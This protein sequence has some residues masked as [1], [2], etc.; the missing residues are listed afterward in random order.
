MSLEID[1]QML[2]LIRMTTLQRIKQTISVM[3]SECI[4]VTAPDLQQESK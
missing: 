2:T 1:G 4:A 3:A